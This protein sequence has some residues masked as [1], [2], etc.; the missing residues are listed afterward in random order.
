VTVLLR[1]KPQEEEEVVENKATVL[2]ELKG[3]E[4][5]RKYTSI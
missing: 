1:S 2:D 4:A 3:L 5:A